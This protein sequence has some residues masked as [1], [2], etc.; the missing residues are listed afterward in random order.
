MSQ[1]RSPANGLQEFTKR[2]RLGDTDSNVRTSSISKK[3]KRKFPPVQ[4]GSGDDVLK[5]E[6]KTMLGEANLQKMV[7]EELEDDPPIQTGEIIELEVGQ[8]SSTGKTSTLLKFCSHSQLN[9]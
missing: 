1:S 2:Q 3:R 5:R 7:D 9:R 4:D 6:V 8:M